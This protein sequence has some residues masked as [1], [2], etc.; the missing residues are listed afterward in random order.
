MVYGTKTPVEITPFGD[1]YKLTKIEP[2]YSSKVA[3]AIQRAEHLTRP[4]YFLSFP[5]AA[6]EFPRNIILASQIKTLE[7]IL[8]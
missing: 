6:K 4:V 1:G 2:E 8:E 7:V 3:Q 5:H